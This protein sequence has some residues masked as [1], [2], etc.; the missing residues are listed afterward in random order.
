MLHF[1]HAFEPLFIIGSGPYAYELESWIKDDQSVN[2]QI[3]AHDNFHSLPKGAQCM[4]GFQTMEYRKSFLAKIQINDYRWPAFSHGS[5]VVA[6]G[7]QISQGVVINPQTVIGHQAQLGKHN[8]IGILCKVG[9]FTQLGDNVVV[10]PG[11]MIGGSSTIG[12]DVY[13]GQMCSV[14]DKIAIGNNMFFTMNSVI[15]KNITASGKYY[16]N[17]LITSTA[18]PAKT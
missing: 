18:G 9:H 17:R 3:V 1:Y 15:S 11:T 2:V 12:N 6:S 13:F 10:A 4:L 5:A 7:A 16:G 8:N 14:K